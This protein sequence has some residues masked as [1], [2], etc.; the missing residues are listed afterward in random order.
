VVFRCGG[1]QVF[2]N[3]PITFESFECLFK[4]VISGGLKKLINIG[5]GLS[6]FGDF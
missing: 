2:N 5:G 6:A 1:F 4:V 3:I